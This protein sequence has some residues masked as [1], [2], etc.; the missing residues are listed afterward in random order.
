MSTLIKY[1]WDIGLKHLYHLWV[2]EYPKNTPLMDQGSSLS[3]FGEILWTKKTH[4]KTLG[5]RENREQWGNNIEYGV[6]WCNTKE[7]NR[8]IKQ[9]AIKIASPES[10]FGTCIWNIIKQETSNNW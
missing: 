7:G 3:L 2:L 10:N 5:G 6:F 8:F 4:S 1:L 9:Y